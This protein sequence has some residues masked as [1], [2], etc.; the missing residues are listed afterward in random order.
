MLSISMHAMLGSTGRRSSRNGT[1]DRLTVY[2]VPLRPPPSLTSH[3]TVFDGI[4]LAISTSSSGI[5]ILGSALV[6]S[7][8]WNDQELH[9]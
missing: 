3:Y 1:L 6:S 7:V 4:R 9:L 5:S 2:F 8:F